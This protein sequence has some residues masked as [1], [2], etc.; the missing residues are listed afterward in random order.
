MKNSMFVL[1]LTVLLSFSFLQAQDFA[2]VNSNTEFKTETRS[3]AKTIDAKTSTTAPRFYH[4]V[5]SFEPNEKLSFSLDLK[6][7][8]NVLIQVINNDDIIVYEG[9]VHNSGNFV[10]DA[11]ILTPGVY[12]INVSNSEFFMSKRFVKHPKGIRV[13]D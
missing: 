2:V 10:Y 8:Y 7:D 6:N 9:S 4:T 13:L 1:T 11:N 3:I 12:S 5:K